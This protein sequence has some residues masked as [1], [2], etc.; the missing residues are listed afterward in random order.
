MESSVM[1][2]VCGL[3]TH[4]YPSVDSF[5][6]HICRQ[7]SDGEFMLIMLAVI[8]VVW[9]RSNFSQFRIWPQGLPG[10]LQ[11][12]SGAGH[13]LEVMQTAFTTRNARR[14]L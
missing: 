10:W 14:G 6:S 1:W 11:V 8:S 7:T 9:N 3:S 2:H 5:L 4:Q 12:S 13:V